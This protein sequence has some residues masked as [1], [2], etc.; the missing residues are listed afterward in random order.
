MFEKSNKLVRENRQ[1]SGTSGIS[2]NNSG[3]GFVPAFKNS[4][5]GEVEISRFCDGRMAPFH[6]IEG[7]P[8]HWIAEWDH[9]GRAIEIKNTVV[10]GFVR[11]GEFFTRQEAAES[12]A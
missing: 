6:L 2:Q 7:L 1:F 8:D 5:S 4:E 11:L 10:S 3:S 12:V 9:Q